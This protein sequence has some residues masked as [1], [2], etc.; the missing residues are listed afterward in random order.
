MDLLFAHG[1]DRSPILGRDADASTAAGHASPVEPPPPGGFLADITAAAGDLESQR[2]AV[3]AAEGAAGDRLVALVRELV[4]LR[5]GEQ[6][7]AVVPIRVPPGQSAEAAA[8]WRR[9][10]YPAL[11]GEDERRRPR[12][13]LVLGDLDGV[14]LD[15]QQVLAH[16]GFLGRLACATED[17]YAAYVAK[18]LA[19]QRAPR[20]ER[21]RALFYTVHDGTDATAAGHTKLV[22]P[23]HDR[24]AGHRARQAAH[25]PGERGRAARRAVARSRRAARAGGGAP[26]G[27]AAVDEPRPRPAAA[28]AVVAHRGARPAG[29]DELRRRGRAHPARRRVGAVP[30]RRA[31]DLLRVLRR[32]HAPAQR[33]PPLARH[34]RAARHGRARSGER[35]AARARPG[36]RLR[37]RAG[38]GRARQPR[39]TAGDPR[40]HRPRVELQLRGAARRPAISASPAPT[41]RRTSST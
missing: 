13:L 2:W 1:D 9:S 5:A 10:A 19:S 20:H 17:G 15:T 41:G 38:Q 11:Y 29:R 14:S 31:V 22:Q 37:L 12:Y 33:L 25:V 8:E 27:R 7:D 6:G 4:A 3:V 34:A 16:D 24:C 32:R 39:R 21:A 26:P 18:V 36:R 35:G 28:P 30:P 23:C 40:P